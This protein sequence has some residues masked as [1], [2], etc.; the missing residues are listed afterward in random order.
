ME[1]LEMVE[2]FRQLLLKT[3]GY[4]DRKPFSLYD[5]LLRLF[6]IDFCTQLKAEPPTALAHF[7]I[8]NPSYAA[9]ISVFL[10]QWRNHVVHYRTYNLISGFSS[11]KLNMDDVVL[12]FNIPALL[13]V[14]TFESCERRIIGVLRDRMIQGEEQ[15]FDEIREVIKKRLDGYWCI[16]QMTFDH[17]PNHYKTVY[18]ALEIDAALFDLRK[19]YDGGFH[20]LS[21]EKMFNAYASEIFRFDQYYRKFSELADLIE[22]AGWDILKS[23][24][25][26]VENC[27]SGWFMDQISLKWG[28]LLD[29][30]SSKEA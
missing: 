14:M 4:H 26:T 20:F 19:K 22:P 21:A 29:D 9:N 10:S 16:F 17:K 27:Y 2:P 13:E 25:Q 18:N 24:R 15:G 1:K 11:K 23:L 7:N 12:A 5:F 3:F 8:P 30:P 6:V 28:D